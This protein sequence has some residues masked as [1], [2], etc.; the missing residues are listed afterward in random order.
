MP[1]PH[2]ISAILAVLLC[3]A[4]YCFIT[5]YSEYAVIQTRLNLIQEQE[6]SARATLLRFEQQIK[7]A[8]RVADFIAKAQRTGLAKGRW[9]RFFVDL[10]DT[11]FSFSQIKRILAQT[12]HSPAYFFTPDRLTITL[13]PPPENKEIA[14]PLADA[15]TQ[16]A[17]AADSGSSGGPSPGKA[18]EDDPADVRVSLSGQF[19]V[20]HRRPNG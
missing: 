6:R 14:P 11:L 4:G 8:A 17:E 9:D 10:T 2:L 3:A 13:A 12:C 15:L 16:P 18:L 20:R 1:K 19:L 5:A 7:E